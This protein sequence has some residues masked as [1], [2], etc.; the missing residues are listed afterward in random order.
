LLCVHSNSCSECG[1]RYTDPLFQKNIL[2]T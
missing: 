1:K 2:I